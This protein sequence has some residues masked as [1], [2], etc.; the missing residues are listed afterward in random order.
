MSAQ[1]NTPHEGGQ[2]SCD[3]P[4][5]IHEFDVVEAE[6]LPNSDPNSGIAEALCDRI[7]ARPQ[8]T[9][10]V[11]GTWIY[12]KGHC[13]HPE[14]HPA[15]QIWWREDSANQTTYQFNVFCD[16]SARYWWRDQM[17]DGTKLKPWGAPPVKGVFAIAFEVDA[18][19]Q[20][21][22]VRP[23]QA[24][25]LVFHV[26][27]INDHNLATVSSGKPVSELVYQ[28]TPLVTFTPDKD[29]FAV[30]FEQVGTAENGKIRGFLVLR[31]TVGILTQTVVNATYPAG[32]DVNT[33]NEKDER[34][35]FAKEEGRYMFTVT[36]RLSGPTNRQ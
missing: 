31:T 5:S 2:P 33:I 24:T 23:A 20:R 9:I 19:S 30:S 6:I 8:R 21:L 3:D 1:W 16:A 14:I 13:C 22:G 25:S 32:T 36:Q 11:Y 12:D 7:N 26:T 10:G 34:K 18:P 29:A 28:D 4:E 35:V 27:S 17:D 15:E